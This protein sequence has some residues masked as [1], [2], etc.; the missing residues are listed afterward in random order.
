[1]KHPFVSLAS[2]AGSRVFLLLALLLLMLVPCGLQAQSTAG[3][4]SGTITDKTGAV[5]PRAIVRL[6]SVEQG[7]VRTAITNAGG[8]YEFIDE[9]A[10]HYNLTASSKGFQTSVTRNIALA[11]RQQL[12]VNIALLVGSIQQVVTVSGNTVSTINTET[13]TVSSVAT[14]SDVAN[15]P[16]NTRASA[17]GTSPLAIVAT[18]PGVQA[19]KGQ[20]GLQ[21]QAPYQT[22]IAVDGVT[23]QNAN[24][25]QPFA[26][27]LPSTESISEVSASGV[28]NSAQYGSP[29]EIVVTTKGGTNEIHGSAFWYQQNAAFDAIPYTYPTTKVKPKLIGNTFGGS[30]GGPVMIPRLYNGH[31]KTFFFV[32]YEGW[33]HPSQVTEQ[34]K[35]P[36]TLM[37]QGDFSQYTSANFHGLTDPYTG[38]NWG[39]TIPSSAISPIAQKMLSFYPDPNVGSPSLYTDNSIPNCI[40]NKDTSASSNQ[41]DVRIDQYFG[42]NQKFLL[43][44]RF[45]WKNAPIMQAEP[46][47]VP[48]SLQNNQS[49]VTKLTGI[50]TIT[51]HL[52]NEAG[53]GFTLFTTGQSNGFNGKAFTQSLGFNGLQNLFFN[54]LPELDF[55]NLTAMN[56]DRLDKLSKSNTY[57]YNDVANWTLGRHQ[58]AF[59]GS[60]TTL[61]AITP[62]GF[63]GADNYGTYQ[64]NTSNSAGLF[65]GVDFGD[66]LLGTPYQ[67]F[68]DVVQQDNDGISAHYHLF[69]DDQWRITPRLTLSYGIRYEIHPPYHDPHGN[70]GNFV[71][72]PLSGEVIYPDG[73]ANLL[74]QNFLASANACN[75]DGI[76][77]TNDKEINGAPCM[78]VL[79]NSKAGFPGGLK[80]YQHY[81]FFPRFGFALRPFHNDKTVVRGGFGMYHDTQLGSV[82]YSLTGTLGSQTTQYT[83]TYD[84]ATHAIGYAW[85]AISTTTGSNGCSD[86][87]GQDYF[88]TSN[89]AH[90]KDPYTE[91]WS[92]SVDRDLGSGYALRL[93]YIG[94]ASHQLGWNP[95]QNT[96]PFSSTTSATTQPFSALKYPNWGRINTRAVGGNA[97]LNSFQVE[98]S[99]RFQGGLEFNSTWTYTRSLGDNQGV[100]NNS[101]N[102]DTGGSSSSSIMDRAADYGNMYATSRHLWLTTMVYD[103]PFGRGRAFGSSMPR[104]ANEI[105]GGW[106]LSNIFLWQ[107]GPFETP[108]FPSGQGDPSG[109]GSGLNGS[110]TGWDGGHRNQIPDKVPNVP[111]LPSSQGRLDW[112]NKAAY[113]CPGYAGWTPGTSCTTGSGSGEF[114]NPIGRFGNAGTGSVEGPGMVNLSSGLVKSFHIYRESTLQV[115]GTFT[116]VLNHT[117]LGDPVM[118]IN[119]PSFGEVTS[120]VGSQYGGARTGQVSVRIDF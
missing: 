56:A 65:T 102:G 76:N 109:T 13:P 73:K 43:W 118:T 100:G 86:C 23:I 83:N 59:G 72:V 47:D 48:S 26:Q 70:I 117:N 3:S 1:M 14:A 57:V 27:A 10:G 81:L 18:L 87:Y 62:L 104:L 21:G 90:W 54:G 53:F 50:W 114:P 67:T 103:L 31:N 82:F 38:A 94:S 99:R 7:A 92:L 33:Q 17:T 96:L 101:F 120:S 16:V 88:G 34:Y 40:V 55:N 89:T 2:T 8:T 110:K 37:K 6:R 77:N 4:I 69:I 71:P 36:S 68:Y 63:H 5:I 29:G 64:F 46:L 116:D 107:T 30:F 106:R 80:T 75:P 44:G 20:Y 95:D 111:L 42:A 24:N 39:T 66:F 9:K 84:A 51:P 60:I 98:A 115:A 49:R 32:A 113:V 45:T 105:L 79:P 11:A 108:Y 12:R 93:S 74:A 61:Q 19:T 97:N 15:L 91:Q 112:I 52:I 58:V 22:T 85:P 119:S 41:F 28:M 35:V 78:P 25:N